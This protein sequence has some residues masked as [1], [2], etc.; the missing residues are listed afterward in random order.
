MQTNPLQTDSIDNLTQQIFREI[1]Q[2]NRNTTN[3]N[4]RNNIPR[5]RNEF[6]RNFNRL[7]DTVY[8][9]MS[10][11]NRN[12]QIYNTNMR[13]FLNFSNTNISILRNQRNNSLLHY[14]DD[15]S[16]PSI[17]QPLNQNIPPSNNPMPSVPP[18]NQ[19]EPPLNQTSGGTQAANRSTNF[20]TPRP[21][22]GTRSNEQM[23]QFL[24]SYFTVNPF[25]QG[26]ESIN[27]NN[28]PMTRQEINEFTRTF[29]YQNNINER[30]VQTCPI[31]MEPFSEGD[32]LCQIKGCNHVFKKNVLLH[33]LERSSQCPVCRY[34]I[35]SYIPP[36]TTSVESVV[37][38][39]SETSDIE[40]DLH[41]D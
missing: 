32:E 9:Q 10:D 29:T 36:N 2:I 41:V 31:S 24:F 13:Q 37:N 18:P 7:L 25:Q 17:R 40:D 16:F 35:R 1:S 26:T 38:D 22:Q 14:R 34:N 21:F 5:N 6:D 23:D 27:P 28:I 20:N 8:E 12:M 30:E 15:I 19:P 33:W 39:E 11:Y 4:R 3:S